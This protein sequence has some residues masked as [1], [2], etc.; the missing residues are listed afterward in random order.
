MEEAVI[1]EI[2]KQKESLGSPVQQKALTL[3]GVTATMYL[4]K[5]LKQ[6]MGLEI[7]EVLP[8]RRSSGRSLNMT[9]EVLEDTSALKYIWDY[10]QYYQY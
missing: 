7:T 10:C 6:T 5:Q 4:P 1:D 2:H 3:C 8:L 9:R